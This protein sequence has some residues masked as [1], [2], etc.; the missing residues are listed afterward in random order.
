[1]GQSFSTYVHPDLFDL[2]RVRVPRTVKVITDDKRRTEFNL[3]KIGE[4]IYITGQ[5]W[6]KFYALNNLAQMDR[7]L[8]V[9]QK[10]GELRLHVYDKPRTKRTFDDLPYTKSLCWRM[11]RYLTLLWGA[12]SKFQEP[13]PPA[14]PVA[15]AVVPPGI[16]A[17]PPAPDQAQP[18]VPAQGPAPAVQPAPQEAQH[19]VP[20]LPAPA[21]ACPVHHVVK[22]PP[23]HINNEANI[24][25]QNAQAIFVFTARMNKTSIRH[26]EMCT[27]AC[28]F[29]TIFQMP[30]PINI[31]ILQK[32]EQIN[33][34]I[35]S[36]VCVWNVYGGNKMM[37][38]KKKW[39]EMVQ[40]SELAIHDWCAF[41]IKNEGG[42]SCVDVLPSRGPCLEKLRLKHVKQPNVPPPSLLNVDHLS[43]S[44]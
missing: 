36:T 5:A 39:Q 12:P 37:P 29:N 19:D 26:S 35:A 33:R 24:L 41:Q 8:V 23:S 32:E 44:S 3:E 9:L 15:V 14:G 11:K 13:R 2:W 20:I 21:L 40:Q 10:S 22:P 25:A 4:G 18:G 42:T 28:A 17:V 43:S 16:A 7:F 38:E 31:R 1:M 27:P 30:L 34:L 6:R